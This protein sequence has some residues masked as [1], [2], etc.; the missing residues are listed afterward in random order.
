[1]ANTSLASGNA[2]L[3]VSTTA[4]ASGNAGLVIVPIA[5]ASGNAALAAYAANPGLQTGEAIGLIIALS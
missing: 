2:A 4:L 5:Q 3:E 1:L